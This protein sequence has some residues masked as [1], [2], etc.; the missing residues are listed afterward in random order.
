MVAA[1]E[2]ADTQAA[3][4]V[5]ISAKL[6]SVVVSEY[7]GALDE[8]GCY[9]GQGTAA[10]KNGNRYE[11]TFV[12]GMMWGSGICTWLKQGTRTCSRALHLM[13]SITNLM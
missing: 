3:E 13:S 4:Q 9:T 10:F 2:V 8:H 5:E 7:T 11:G 1:A 12:R 6:S